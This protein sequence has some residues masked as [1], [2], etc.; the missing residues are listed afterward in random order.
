MIKKLAAITLIILFV[1]T[2]CGT[3]KDN[4][5]SQEAEN[6]IKKVSQIH[7]EQNPQ[8]IK[9]KTAEEETSK[10]PMYIVFLR[11]NFQK[12]ELKSKN[13]QFSMTADGKTVWAL[14]ADTWEDNE[15]ID[16]Y[17]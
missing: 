8:V 7:G 15:K 9:I 16:I 17:D 12:G 4:K 13:L 11:G 1:F 5:V 10:K 2:G 3:K 6:T 14:Q